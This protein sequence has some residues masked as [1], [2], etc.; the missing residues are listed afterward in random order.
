MLIKCSVEYI[1][2]LE[3]FKSTLNKIEISIYYLKL[4]KFLNY[5]LIIW[6]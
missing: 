4:D 3:G 1:I 2:L 6:N 5:L